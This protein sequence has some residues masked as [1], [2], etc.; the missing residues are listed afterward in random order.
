MFNKGRVVFLGVIMLF[1]FPSV[2]PGQ[3]VFLAR[4]ISFKHSGQAI[5]LKVAPLQEGL[6][7]ILVVSSGEET[8]QDT[9]YAVNGI[10]RICKEV[11]ANCWTQNE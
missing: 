7:Q 1:L 6:T 2:V 4:S 9:S 8:P 10:L 3:A 5:T 11:G